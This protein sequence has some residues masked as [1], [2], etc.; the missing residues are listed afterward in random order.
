MNEKI[1]A[2]MQDMLQKSKEIDQEWLCV[3]LFN[4][5]KILE[6]HLKEPTEDRC[7]RCSCCWEYKNEITYYLAADCCVCV[8]CK[9]P[10]S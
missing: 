9:R 10:L 1:E 6:R 3:W 2:I 8:D 5:R 4:I 7:G